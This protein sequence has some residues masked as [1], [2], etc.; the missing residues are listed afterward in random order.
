MA[1]K[2][3]KKIHNDKSHSALSGGHHQPA[4]SPAKAAGP[5]AWNHRNTWIILPLRFSLGLM[6]LVAGLQ[7]LTGLFSGSTQTISFFTSLG[8]PASGFF[9]W[10]VAWVELIGGIFLILGLFN[11]WVGLILGIIML[12]ATVTT[13][14]S[15]F[16]WGSLTKHLVYIT[17]LFVIMFNKIDWTLTCGWKK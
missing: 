11:L 7:K 15:P 4:H 6:F 3:T 12:V 17:S 2:K 5:N 9:A 14:L 8:I 1:K 16:D 10:L 13:T